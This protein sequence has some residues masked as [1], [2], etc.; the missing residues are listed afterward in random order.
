[1]CPHFSLTQLLEMPR[2]DI[3]GP[4]LAVAEF[5]VLVKIPASGNHV[6]FEFVR[7]LRYQGRQVCLCRGAQC[8]QESQSCGNPFHIHL[9]IA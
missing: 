3:R 9:P 6:A 5:R 4:K 7:L 1:M 2:H 8:Y